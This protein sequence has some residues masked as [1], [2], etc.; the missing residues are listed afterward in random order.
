MAKFWPVPSLLTNCPTAQALLATCAHLW[1][2]QRRINGW[3]VVPLPKEP[4]AQASVADT[5]RTALSTAPVP[6]LGLATLA[7]L[8][9]FQ[10][11]IRVWAPPVARLIPGALSPTAQ[12][13]VG[14]SARTPFRMLSSPATFVLGTT[15]QVEPFQCSVSVLSMP[16]LSRSK[17][18][19]QA[20][21]GESTVTPLRLLSSVPGLGGWLPLQ[22]PQVAADA[23]T[24]AGATPGRAPVTAPASISGMMSAR[25]R[26]P[27][28]PRR[29]RLGL[30]I[31]SRLP[32]TGHPA[33]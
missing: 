1:P 2:F 7:Q 32:K 22:A 27:A 31:I 25:A 33:L 8:W 24:A 16:P 26:R 5:V 21:Q 3:P 17:P 12:M 30:V 15:V 10:C 18:T 23:D 28:G 11:R 13:S 20:S 14:D 19:A 29:R 9:P 4:T 6:G